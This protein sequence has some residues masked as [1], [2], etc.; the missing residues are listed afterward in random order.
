MA[1]TTLEEHQDT[2]KG[3]TLAQLEAF[4]NEA[5]AQGGTGN[6]LIRARV[7]FRAGI[8][9][10]SVQI[11]LGV[12]ENLGHPLDAFE[13]D[14]AAIRPARPTQ[15]FDV[16]RVAPTYRLE[17]G[18]SL[19]KKKQG[20]SGGDSPAPAPTPVPAITEVVVVD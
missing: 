19:E 20:S 18:K 5:R 15:L 2:S 17:P 8:K 6:E 14:H 3:M 11:D 13:D 1:S 7:N 12:T 10:L 4:V 9:A 16:E